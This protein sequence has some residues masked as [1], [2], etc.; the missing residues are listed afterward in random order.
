MKTNQNNI[1]LPNSLAKQ[2]I[3]EPEEIDNE[4]KRKLNMIIL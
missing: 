1:Y 2:I 3:Y 4:K